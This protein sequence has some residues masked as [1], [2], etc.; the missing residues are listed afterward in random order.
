MKKDL[1]IFNHSNVRIE[2]S[3]EGNLVVRSRVI[4]EQL[5][6]RHDNVIRDLEQILKT[7]ESSSL[8]ISSFYEV[9]GQ[10]RKYK[11]YLLTE[12]GFT[13]YMFNIQGYNEFKLAYI[14]EFDRMKNALNNPLSMLLSMNKESLALTCIQLTQQVQEK[15]EIIIAQTPKVEYH[16][17]VLKPNGLLTMTMVAKDM[18]MSAKTLNAMLNVLGL[19]YKQS[20]TW[21]LYSEYKHLLEDGYFDYHISEHGQLLKATELGRMLIIKAY[22]LRSVKLALKEINN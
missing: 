2:R 13:L 12:K 8:I 22:E 19:I 4:A 9:E 7:S 21:Y 17:N 16:D 18:S 1:A 6:K 11:E 20:Q 3:A 5:G 15:D 14:N 10:N